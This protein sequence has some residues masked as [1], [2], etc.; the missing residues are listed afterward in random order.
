MNRKSEL[1]TPEEKG[2]KQGLQ[3]GSKNEKIEIAK[4]L[5]KEGMTIE[6]ISQITA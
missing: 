1:E 5:K 4:K 6:K 3:K 2:V